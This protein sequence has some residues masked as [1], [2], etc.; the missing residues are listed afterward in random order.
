MDMGLGKTAV[1]LSA[2]RHYLTEDTTTRHILVIAPKR[3][4]EHTW[5]DEIRKWSEFSGLKYTIIAGERKDWPSLLKQTI[6]RSHIHLVGAHSV[7]QLVEIA[8][9]TFPVR[10][11][12]PW[13]TVVIDESSQ[14]KSHKS[15]R[16]KSLKSRL[17][18]ISKLILMTGTPVPNGFMDLWSQMYLLDQGER[19]ERSIARFETIYF[20]KNPF[21]VWS[22]PEL[23]P[24]AQRQI[25]EKIKDITISMEARDYL[26]LEPMQYR[27]ISVQPS[28]QLQKQYK[29]MKEDLVVELQGGHSADFLGQT[30]RSIAAPTAAAAANKMLQMCG[31]FIYDEIRQTYQVDEGKAEALD[32]LLEEAQGQYKNVLLFYT[33]KAEE[34]YILKKYAD[35]GATSIQEP[36]AIARWNAG[37]VPILVLHP[38]SGGHGLNLQDGGHTVVWYNMTYNLEHWLQGNKRVHRMGQT[39]PV[40]VYALTMEGMLDSHIFSQVLTEKA[41]RQQALID[42][43]KD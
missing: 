6:H 19:L 21:Y 30:I 8:K 34:E 14:F 15:L 36:D 24:D 26:D 2:L 1:V 22:K 20:T 7:Q 28:P 18:F 29:K 40:V 25:T 3:V 16:Y 17:P 41:D 11:A 31:G 43:L 38:A 35:R 23:R 9:T 39:K 37:E 10:E 27:S 4:A 5:P 33:Y 32:Q 13:D 12:W 42:A